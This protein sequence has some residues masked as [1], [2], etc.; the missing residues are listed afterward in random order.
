[1]ISAEFGDSR[2]ASPRSDSALL[3]Q[4]HNPTHKRNRH[5]RRCEHFRKPQRHAGRSCCHSHI[6]PG[7]VVQRGPQGV[8]LHRDGRALH[9]LG[10]LCQGDITLEHPHTPRAQRS[11][12]RSWHKQFT[13]CGLCALTRRV[14]IGQCA[15]AFMVFIQNQSRHST[16]HVF[17]REK[18]A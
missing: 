9:G 4:P 2:R 7:V 17:V 6:V 15:S 11:S 18:C 5:E 3:R 12:T 10:D 8:R 13:A 16:A 1:M 14:V